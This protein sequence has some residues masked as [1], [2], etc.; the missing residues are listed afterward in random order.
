MERY[1]LEAK[2]GVLGHRLHPERRSTHYK[3]V[4]AEQPGGIRYL[5]NLGSQNAVPK[6]SQTFNTSTQTAEFKKESGT[7]SGEPSQAEFKPPK[8]QPQPEP[9]PTQVSINSGALRE[10]KEQRK[11]EEEKK[12][13]EEAE[14][15]TAPSKAPPFLV[16]ED[17]ASE[18]LYGKYLRTRYPGSVGILEYDKM[19]EGDLAFSAVFRFCLRLQWKMVEQAKEYVGIEDLTSTLS[20]LAQQLARELIKKVSKEIVDLGPKKESEKKEYYI[21]E[22]LRNLITNKVNEAVSKLSHHQNT[23]EERLKAIQQSIDSILSTEP[24]WY[25]KFYYYSPIGKLEDGKFEQRSASEFEREPKKSPKEQMEED[26]N[27]AEAER[28][29]RSKEFKEREGER[30]SINEMIRKG[31]AWAL[32]EARKNG[33][34]KKWNE[35]N[36]KATTDPTFA[37][38]LE[39]ERLESYIEYLLSIGKKGEARLIKEW[40]ARGHQHIY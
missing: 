22:Y 15:A 34:I 20:D 17:N 23:R 11:E 29:K 3:I 21:P 37:K 35:D 36:R 14:N 6:I 26:L 28:E 27:K 19:I 16:P 7:G 18:K 1:L 4:P 30:A 10:V 32:K 38:K 40:I 9:E 25:S 8:P 12:T 5:V 2:L 24:K 31:I 33:Q 13:R 39:K